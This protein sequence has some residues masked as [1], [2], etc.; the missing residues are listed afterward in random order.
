MSRLT[1]WIDRTAY[2]AH[3]DNW[4]NQLF[5]EAVLERLPAA[6]DVLDLGAGAGIVR[7]LNVRGLGPRVHGI[8]P[9]PRVLQNPFLDDAH[10]GSAESIPYP[11]GSFDVVFCN[12]VLE[13]L[14]DPGR[15][16]AEVARVLRPGG[17]FFA[18]T[19]NRR[20]YV[21]LISHLTPHR[22]HQLV[23]EWRGR[24]R[25]DTFPTLYRA[26]TARALRRWAATAGLTVERVRHVEGRPEYLR[27]LAPTYLLGLA[28]ERLVNAT[29]L[30]APWRVVL[31]ASFRKN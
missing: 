28:Y 31:I 23:N 15:A 11:D 20:H 3:A 29:E 4:D 12:N 24:D 21:A 22:F 2:P 18:K 1:A 30:L 25:E 16:F 9:D 7:E 10:V 8:D 26:N 19:P 5:R 27:M 17:V 13:H 6:R 14:P